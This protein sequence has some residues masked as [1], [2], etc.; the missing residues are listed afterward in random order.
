MTALLLCGLLVANPVDVKGEVYRIN[1][2]DDNLIIK[3]DYLPFGQGGDG[4]TVKITE[5]G[6]SSATVNCGYLLEEIF[7]QTLNKYLQ[8]KKNN[9]EQ[10][11]TVIGIRD[12]YFSVMIHDEQVTFGT[13]SE[14]KLFHFKFSCGMQSAIKLI[15]AIR[16]YRGAGDMHLSAGKLE[17]VRKGMKYQTIIHKKK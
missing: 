4:L 13:N 8:E 1:D 17:D 16:K 14:G 5:N 7:Q 15:E 11:L 2:G 6:S 12:P 10:S 9:K 3:T